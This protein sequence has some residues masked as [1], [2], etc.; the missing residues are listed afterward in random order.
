MRD[1]GS[2]VIQT[3]RDLHL[4][5]PTVMNA[6]RTA[7]REVVGA[8]LPEVEVLGID[9]T[10]RGRTRREQDPDTEKW[11]IT[12]DRW[13]TGFVDALGS[14]GLLG[15]VERRTVADVLA[16]LSTTP[17][18][19]RKAIR[20]VAIDMSAIYRSAI[21][22]G[23]PEATVVVDHFHVVQVANKMVSLVR[24]R[25]TA[26]IRGRRGRAS[27]P[28]W[29]ARRRLL[30]NREDLDH[31]QFERT[32]NPLLD[33]GKIGQTLLTSESPSKTCAPSSPWPALTPT[34]TKWAMP[35]GSSSPGARTPTCPKSAPSRPP[36]TAGGPRLRR[37]STPDTAMPR[38]KGSTA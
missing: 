2:T 26:E 24:R 16:C 36:S 29:K 17:L 8:P 19:W 9:E 30:C 14:G 1:G 10:R 33:E 3:A 21:R 6:F 4:S 27:D 20:Y 13:H 32:W 22:T 12:R 31:E 23:L 25:T 18:T 35:V 37:S 7:A 5:W 38:A 11:K 34:G 15:Q 28:E